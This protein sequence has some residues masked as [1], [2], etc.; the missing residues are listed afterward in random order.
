MASAAVCCAAIL[1]PATSASATTWGWTGFAGV[2]SETAYD[3]DL[4]GVQ[5]TR[6][7]SIPSNVAS[8]TGSCSA[9][10]GTEGDG[11]GQPFVY[12]AL[13]LVQDNSGYNSFNY[14]GTFHQ[15]NGYE[16]WL[17]MNDT[18]GELGDVI[19]PIWSHPIT[20]SNQHQFYM[21][22]NNGT[23]DDVLAVKIGTV[24]EASMSAAGELG[25][26][27]GNETLS[28]SQ[29]AVT[30]YQGT[31]LNWVYDLG[32]WQGFDMGSSDTYNND[33]ENQ[34]GQF[35]MCSY[36]VSPPDSNT[37]NFGQNTSNSNCTT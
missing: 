6:Y 26:A 14:F 20:G 8:G 25:I 21:W 10:L 22:I 2:V 12:Q 35:A 11:S 29:E 37:A 36:V 9:L 32:P 13:E 4:T 23:D 27:I 3:S 31:S 33:A 30:S 24:Q 19:V 5:V 18:A 7:D 28:T 17:F 1:I 15:C 16:W 34:N